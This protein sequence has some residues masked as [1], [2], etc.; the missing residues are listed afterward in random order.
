MAEEF[1]K[2]DPTEEALLEL[3]AAEKARLFERTRVD[4]RALLAEAL[5]VGRVPRRWYAN[6]VMWPAAA[7][8]VLALGVAAWVFNPQ[9]DST[10]KAGPMASQIALGPAA[11]GNGSFFG[12]LTG[13][14]SGGR[15]ACRDYDYD[16]DGDVDLADFR[17]YQLACA[18]PSR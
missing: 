18:G 4:A 7:S 9:N 17:A 3:D 12:C 16:L 14:G 15:S 5:P 8:V 10:N 1:N 6:G 13:P 11:P 2:L